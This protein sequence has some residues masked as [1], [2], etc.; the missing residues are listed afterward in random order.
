ME[1]VLPLNPQPPSRVYQFLLASKSGHLKQDLVPKVK[2]HS[3]GRAIFFLRALRKDAF[4]PLA[5][6]L[7]MAGWCSYPLCGTRD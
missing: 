3:Q 5:W 4:L 2:V 7:V 6:S 1:L